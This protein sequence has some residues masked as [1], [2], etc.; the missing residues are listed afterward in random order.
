MTHKVDNK[1][2]RLI[3][4][5]VDSNISHALSYDDALESGR[6]SSKISYVK[7]ESVFHGVTI[8]T[9]ERLRLVDTTYSKFKVAWLMEPRAYA[10]TRYQELESLI[11]K[12]DM[13]LT[14]DSQLLN[15]YPSISK[16]IPADGIFLDSESIFKKSEKNKLCS[17]LYSEKT[18]LE[19]HR[20]R[21]TIAKLIAD[22]GRNID[23]LGSGTG[24]RLAKKSDA[25]CSY[26]FSIVVENS[27][28]QYYITEKIFDCFATRTVP[29]YWG[30]DQVL[31]EFNSDGIITFRTITD[32]TK[33]LDNL[34]SQNYEKRLSAIDENYRLVLQHYSVDDH[35]ADVISN[36]LNARG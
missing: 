36:F 15:R 11:D 10:P 18:I 23:V 28:D 14:H 35:I 12:F 33:I 1:H 13:V 20:L 19:G 4:N 2:E 32:L 7:N 24:V 26:Y 22:S 9:D 8:F 29:I 30:T 31:Q 16:R 17:M 27:V 3:V 21:H 34:S 6:K 25:L 5:L